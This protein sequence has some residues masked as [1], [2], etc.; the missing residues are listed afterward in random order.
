MESGSC[1]ISLFIIVR[2]HDASVTHVPV[3]PQECKEDYIGGWREKERE[4]IE[5]RETLHAVDAEK[6]RIKTRSILLLSL[7]LLRGW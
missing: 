7:E 5:L 2:E 4:A 3:R 6:V 1:A